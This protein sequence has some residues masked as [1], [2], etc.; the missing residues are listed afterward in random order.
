VED[1]QLGDFLRKV[2]KSR[3]LSIRDLSQQ[4]KAAESGKGVT[5]AEI[6]KI[7]NG[8][9][10]PTFLTLQKLAAALKLPLIIVLNG[11]EAKPDV[12]TV[13]STPEI[14][15]ALP[16]AL[17]RVEVSELLLYCFQLTDE[18][19]AA[20]LGVARSIQGFTQPTNREDSF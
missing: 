19:V 1:F 20:I 8:K 14:A 13:H 9:A 16:Q 11:S 15:Q 5:A 10:N 18:Q 6:S 12:I 4:T 3:K 7:E 17:I 2:R